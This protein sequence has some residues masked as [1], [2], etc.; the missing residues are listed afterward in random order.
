MAIFPR[1]RK[2]LRRQKNTTR[3]W[4]TLRGE[5][6]EDRLA[7]AWAG[8]PPN[9]I[10]P[11]TGAVPVTFN[12]QGD[13]QGTASIAATEIDYYTFLA[14]RAGNYRITTQTPNSN[15][16]TVIGVFNAGGQRMA[17]DDDTPTSTDSDLTV[18]LAAGGRY[19]VGI[20]NY[21]GS[22]PGTYSWIIDGPA[23]GTTVTD[24][25]FEDNDTRSLATNLGTL[26][27]NRSYA[28]LRL[29]DA[30]DWYSFQTTTTGGV[31][32]QVTIDFAN[33]QGNL[34]L[35]LYN[36]AGTLIGSSATT[37]NQ[38]RVSLSGLPAG[39]YFVRVYGA[40]NPAYS[41]SIAA[42]AATSTGNIDLSGASLTAPDTA[43]WGQAISVQ[44]SI[45]NSGSVASPAF[46]VQWYLSRDTTVSSDDVLLPFTSGNTTISHP[47]LA[48]N[49]VAAPFGRTLQ[50]PSSIPAGWTGNTFY[51]VMRTDAGAQVPESNELNNFGQVGDGIDRER[52]TI[53]G[54]APPPT[55]GGGFHIDVVTTGMTAAQMALFQQAADR[56][57]QVI[58]GD[59]PN[60]TYNGIVVDDIRIDASGVYIDG[61]GGVL[62]QAGPDS[63]RSRN[64]AG[65]RIPYHGSMQFDTADLARLQSNG[66]LLPV[67]L[68]EMGHV[69]GIG[70]V[71]DSLV[72]GAGTANPRFIGARATAAYNQ[73]FSRNENGVPVENTGSP[74]TRDSHWRDSI[75]SNEVM[76][77]YLG[78]GAVQPLSRITI[79]ALADMGYTVNFAAADQYV[80]PPGSLTTAG[81]TSSSGA[82][83]LDSDG[84][85]DGPL[86]GATVPSFTPLA[87]PLAPV[88]NVSPAASSLVRRNPISA[89]AADVVHSRDHDLAAS[90]AGALD[91]LL[92][93]I[94]PSLRSRLA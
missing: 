41:L 59:L 75:L 32:N 58:T 18:A 24:D 49:T 93:E 9:F 40:A 46:L 79:A 68:H 63:V 51:L 10:T 30:N 21:S 47:T 92:A 88:L 60:A 36:S 90:R 29:A 54:T 81:S 8:M 14:P 12:S 16:D 55:T 76:T 20:T 11:P 69:L 53:A 4:L 70:T 13:A 89:A 64:S 86:S 83:L 56:W 72:S 38:E 2:I 27:T 43:Q 57:A 82:A 35:E 15:L 94:V 73:I 61:P 50:L 52:I 85:G 19:Y 3:R 6:L 34:N 91:E 74:G 48:A 22:P 78:P 25:S 62:G 33:S 37:T 26:A 7:L 45:R 65:I 42:P 5:R 1:R 28:G 66:T 23:T 71:W 31:A 77:G 17:Y 67:I 39:T 84:I 44:S 80:P 87:G